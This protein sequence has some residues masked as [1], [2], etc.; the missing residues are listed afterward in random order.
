MERRE[1]LK[2]LTGLA[3]L[4][5]ASLEAA[6]AGGRKT[7]VIGASRAGCEY[8]LAH[9]DETI[10]L[11]HGILPAIELGHDQTDAWAEKLL[12]EGVLDFAGSV[13]CHLADPEWTNKA[14]AGKDEEIMPCIACMACLGKYFDAGHIT[15]AVNPETGYEAALP[16]LSEDGAGRLGCPEAP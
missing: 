2:G 13:R 9:P 5:T 4:G 16:S 8:A 15:C 7:L 11:D 14:L 1:F 12:A 6:L 10:L 3:A